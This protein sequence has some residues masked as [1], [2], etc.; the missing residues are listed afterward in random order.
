MTTS[1][2]ISILLVLGVVALGVGTIVFGAGS[3]PGPASVFTPSTASIVQ[4]APTPADALGDQ[5][6]ALVQAGGMQMGSAG[7]HLLFPSDTL[8]PHVK[9]PVM[10]P[11]PGEYTVRG[12]GYWQLKPRYALSYHVSDEA[13]N[14]ASETVSVSYASVIPLSL[15]SYSSSSD[16]ATGLQTIFGYANSESLIA[17]RR[18]L[19]PKRVS[20]GVTTDWYGIPRPTG[21]VETKMVVLVV[22]DNTAFLPIDISEAVSDFGQGLISSRTFQLATGLSSDDAAMLLEKLSN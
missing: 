9:N 22:S 13:L 12:W 21:S 15:L 19:G 10:F 2:H 5:E 14:Q 17:L 1:K 4:S 7:L 6:L 8:D 3:T 11:W 20:G 16:P 18:L